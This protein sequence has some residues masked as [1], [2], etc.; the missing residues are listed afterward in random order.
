MTDPQ[1]MAKLVPKGT[2]GKID[3]GGAR[4]YYILNQASS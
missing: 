1:G 3:A 2:V 4:H